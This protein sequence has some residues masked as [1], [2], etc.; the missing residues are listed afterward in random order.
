MR[1]ILYGK[2]FMKKEFGIDSKILFLPDVFGYAYQIPQILDKSGV[3]QFST[4][5][6]G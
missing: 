6:I 1:H 2:E 3:K 4:T 5:K